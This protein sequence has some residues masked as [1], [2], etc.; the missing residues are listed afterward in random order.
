MNQETY[1]ERFAKTGNVLDY[2]NYIVCKEKK[3]GIEDSKEGEKIGDSISCNG[4]GAIS[5][6]NWGI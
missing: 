4:N 3:D 6:A 5:H 2:L 1:W